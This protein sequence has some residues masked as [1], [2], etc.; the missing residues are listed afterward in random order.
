M[1]KKFT[2][3]EEEVRKTMDMADEIQQ[4]EGNPFLAT[5]VLQQIENERAQETGFLIN[6]SPVYKLAFSIFLI[7][8]NALVVFQMSDLKSGLVQTDNTV[9]I[10]SEYGLVVEDSYELSYNYLLEK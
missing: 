6:L 9:D 1:E 2:H 8:L 4:V 3:I 5:R 10:A 7:A